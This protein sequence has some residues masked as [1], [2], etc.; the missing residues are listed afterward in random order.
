MDCFTVNIKEIGVQVTVD[1]VRKVEHGLHFMCNIPIYH[2]AVSHKDGVSLIAKSAEDAV[3]QLV[4]LVYA[5]RCALDIDATVAYMENPDAVKQR[6]MQ[7]Q[8][9]LESGCRVCDQ[10]LKRDKCIVTK[11]G[12]I[13]HR[14]CCSLPY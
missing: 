9:M 13:F 7:L 11:S 6:N 1:Y 10:Y 14:K 5:C 12:E 3:K 4:N 2:P 8:K